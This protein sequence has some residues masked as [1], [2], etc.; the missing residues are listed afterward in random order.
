MYTCLLSNRIL[1]L[2]VASVAINYIDR[3][4]LSVSAPLIQTQLG[5]STS[6]LGILF[7]AF[8]WTYASVQIFAGWVVDRYPLKWVYAA[9]FLIWSLATAATG[10]TASFGQLLAARLLLGFGESVAYPATSKILV[11]E[12]PESRRGFANAM[13]DAGSKI[14]PGLSTLAGGLLVT[15]YGW[16]PLFLGVGLVSL[17]WLIPW[18]LYARGGQENAAH[19]PETAAASPSMTALLLRREAWGT[20]LGMF[21]LG[22]VW[23]FLLSWLPSYLVKER[24]F[25]MS[26]MAMLGSVPFWGMAGATLA[27]GWCSDA[28][29]RRGASPTRVRKTFLIGGLLLCGAAMLPAVL[30]SDPRWCV[31]WLTAACLLLGLYTSNVW[32]VTQTLAGPVAAGRWS[33][34]QNAIG[35]LGGVVSPLVTGWIVTQTGS[36]LLAFLAASA[37]LAGGAACYLFLLGEVRPVDWSQR[38]SFP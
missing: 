3:G 14:G 10:L 16:R 19:Q 22:Y 5:L 18:M 36:F 13:V 17:L 32:A 6:Q 31:G 33:G 21:A 37:V 20:Y 8:F 30:V 25:S 9:G 7:S 2:L 28:W 12:F 34:I 15:Q 38:R 29:I 26:S 11:R 35:N 1:I 23:Y 24:G 4:L 27:G